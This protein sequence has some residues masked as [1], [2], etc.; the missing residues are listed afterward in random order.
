MQTRKAAAAMDFVA[1][2]PWAELVGLRFPGRNNNQV[3][4][5][6]QPASRLSR[7]TKAPPRLSC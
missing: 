3:P 4:K 5:R 1:F 6:G 2:A 7:I